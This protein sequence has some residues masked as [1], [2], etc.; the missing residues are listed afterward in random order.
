[1]IRNGHP[2]AQFKP[3]V[4][5]RLEV[6]ECH[7]LHRDVGPWWPRFSCSPVQQELLPSPGTPIPFPP[8]STC[9]VKDEPHLTSLVCTQ[10][11]PKVNADESSSAPKCGSDAAALLV[12]G[13]SFLL[14]ALLAVLCKLS[15][16]LS[17]SAFKPL[18]QLFTE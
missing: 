5:P 1:M 7:L 4:R 11:A 17:S 10:G 8:D 12:C 18:I 14:F 15:G 16:S 6:Q 2:D 9:W 3:D 13:F